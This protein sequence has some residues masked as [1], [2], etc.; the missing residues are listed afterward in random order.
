MTRTEKQS[1]QQR[2]KNGAPAKRVPSL[3]EHHQPW[4]QTSTKNWEQWPLKAVR[5]FQ[6]EPEPGQV[7]YATPEEQKILERQQARRPEV[8]LPFIAVEVDL[9]YARFVP[10]HPDPVIGWQLVLNVFASANRTFV[11]GLLRQLYGATD[12]RFPEAELDFNFLVSVVQNLKPRDETEAMLATQI[13]VGQSA[14]LQ[15]AGPPCARDPT[16]DARHV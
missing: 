16:R 8:G 14:S 2:A 7:A 12:G 5:V 6:C 1:A 10:Q 9:D 13:A 11:E 15:F 4:L 3:A